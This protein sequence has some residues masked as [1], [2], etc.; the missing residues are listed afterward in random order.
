MKK[1]LLITL[2]ISILLFMSNCENAEKTKEGNPFIGIWEWQD[3]SFIE[4]F[5]FSENNEVSFYYEDTL[6]EHKLNNP[7]TD[8]GTYQYTKSH[9]DFNWNRMGET[10]ADYTLNNNK[11]V[12]TH[13]KTN[14]TIT[15]VKIN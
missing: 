12:L 5:A 7:S 15:Y 11:L 2:T 10:S 8:T 9:I 1:I 14:K 4:R 6:M 13:S 3:D